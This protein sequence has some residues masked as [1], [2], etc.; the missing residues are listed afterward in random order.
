MGRGD[1]QQ[2][3]VKKL[4]AELSQPL[5]IDADGLNALADAK[6]ELAKHQGQRVLTPHPGEFQRLVGS[7]IT[8]RAQLEAA[9]IELADAA[10]VVVVLK[11]HQTFV[12]AGER[13]FRNDTGNPGMATAGSGD[14][15]TG[16]ITS[17]IGQ[18]LSTFDAASLGVHIHGIAGDFAAESVGEWS[19]IA[20]DV[21]E[22]LP[23]AFKQHASLRGLPIGFQVP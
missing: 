22:N 4:Y 13:C 5:V 7:Q 15:L 1:A 19:L 12:T 16:V 3:I 10:N 8:N 14:V 2:S 6:F 20:T 17:L 11:G 9:A 18:G 21:I 23:A